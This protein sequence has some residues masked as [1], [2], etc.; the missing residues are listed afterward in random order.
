MMRPALL[1]AAF[2]ALAV[3]AICGETPRDPRDLM[4]PSIELTAPAP[5]DTTLSNGM[6]VLVFEN[7]DVPIVTMSAHVSMGSRYLP[8]S[9]RVAYRLLSR[10]WDDGGAG[11]LTPDEVDAAEAANGL[12]LSA[13]GDDAEVV[14]TAYMT[15]QD[16][17]ASL[18]LWRDLLLAPGWDRERLAR[19][20]AQL[21]K[22]IQG[23]NDNPSRL[24]NTWFD[25]LL[26]GPDTPEGRVFSPAEIEAVTRDDLVDLHSRFV[27]PER[28]VVGVAGNLTLAEAIAYLEELFGTWV[29]DRE[30]PPLDVWSWQPSPAPGVYWLPGDFQQCHIRMGRFLDDLTTTSP[31]YPHGN[32][33]SFGVGYMRVYYATRQAGLSYGT[34]TRIDIGRD[35]TR[36]LAFGSTAAENVVELLEMVRQEVSDVRERPLTDN[37]VAAS[38]TFLASSVITR[39]ETA[40]DVVQMYLSDIAEG[41]PAGFSQG[42]VARYNACTTE[43]LAERTREWFDFGPSPVV[44][45]VGQPAGGMADLEALGLGPVTV[46]EPIRFGY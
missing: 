4:L 26:Y 44:L 17:V 21:I 40:G 24:V 16:L 46:L 18:P 15:R 32:L 42:M 13:F 30:S 19:S 27:V 35:R 10:L 34:A 43:E 23:I 1:T 36:V 33:V 28:T 39:M 6:K 38:K 9:D 20:K 45:V 11:A 7:H 22:D 31:L 5:Q 37:E 3:S 14:V 29:V 12:T 2:V 8:N 25:R 41:L